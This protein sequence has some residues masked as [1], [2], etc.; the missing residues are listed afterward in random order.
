MLNITGGSMA[1]LKGNPRLNLV[2]CDLG[3]GRSDFNIDK[4]AE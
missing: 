3:M 2:G 1:G 4:V